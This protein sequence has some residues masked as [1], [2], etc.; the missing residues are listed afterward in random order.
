VARLI[1]FA[2][3]VAPEVD[4]RLWPTAKDGMTYEEAELAA[5]D[6]IAQLPETFPDPLSMG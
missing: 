4:D 2:K 5:R 6:V 1:E 3:E